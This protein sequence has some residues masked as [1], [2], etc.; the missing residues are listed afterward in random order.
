[1]ARGCCSFGQE[2]SAKGPVQQQLL[3]NEEVQPRSN[4]EEG[5]VPGSGALDIEME[6]LGMKE[7]LRQQALQHLQDELQRRDEANRSAGA[8]AFRAA[9]QAHNATQVQQATAAYNILPLRN[10]NKVVPR[11][12]SSSTFMASAGKLFPSIQFVKR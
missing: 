10:S 1:M 5:S 9:Q 3:H 6:E 8:A 4:E 12:V 2:L 11:S 7:Q